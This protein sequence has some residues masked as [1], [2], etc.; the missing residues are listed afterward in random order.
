MGFG[1]EML[2]AGTDT[3]T[4]TV[5]WAMAELIVHPE[6]MKRVQDELDKIVGD[7]NIVQESDLPNLPFLQA[8]VKEVF[9]LH[10][11]AALAL[12]RESTHE[13]DLLGYRLPAHTQL[14]LNLHAIHRDPSVYKNPDAF[15]PDRF[16]ELH[17]KVSHT[18]GSDSFELI[19]FGL[20]RRMCPAF[21]AGS[22][23]VTLILA[24]LLHSFNWSLPG[25]QSVEMLD[26]S[27]TFGTA[28]TLKNSLC[29][30]SQPKRSASL[31]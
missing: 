7:N 27:E 25:S 8:V 13:S 28:V 30:I 4:T 20:G 17:P 5:E 23:I 10:P 29:L 31:Y 12:P 3:S 15:D 21:N 11:P 2:I 14:I 26:L 18:T 1:Q 19:P 22:L 16:L 6:A 9:R 24:H